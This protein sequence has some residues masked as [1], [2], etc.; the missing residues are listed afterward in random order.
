MSK[1]TSKPKIGAEFCNQFDL[2]QQIYLVEKISVKENLVHLRL[3][4]EPRFNTKVP[5]ESFFKKFWAVEKPR[6]RQSLSVRGNG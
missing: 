6:I 5:L 1:P 2:N 4:K 3:K